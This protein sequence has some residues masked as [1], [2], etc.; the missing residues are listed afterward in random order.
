MVKFLN[1]ELGH[2]HFVAMIEPTGASL[3]EGVAGVS[4]EEFIKD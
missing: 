2:P 3:S 4:I 1:E